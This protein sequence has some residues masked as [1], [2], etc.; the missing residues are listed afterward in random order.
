MPS[1]PSNIA[2]IKDYI[3][4]GIINS[5]PHEAAVSYECV[6]KAI[7]QLKKHF[8]ND[9]FILNEEVEMSAEKYQLSL[10]F[11]DDGQDRSLYTHHTSRCRI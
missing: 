10:F 7:G 3:D 8:T 4:Q 6:K 2:T 9:A 5:H 11:T 1:E